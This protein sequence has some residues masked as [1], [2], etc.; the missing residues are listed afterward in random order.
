M[1][2]RQRLADRGYVRAEDEP[3]PEPVMPGQD[4]EAQEGTEAESG[5]TVTPL[6]PAPE[7]EDKAPTPS[8]ALLAELEAHRTAGL[9]AALA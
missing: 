5:S 4:D 3:K 9:Q 1:L 6:R 7:P 8:A 2:R